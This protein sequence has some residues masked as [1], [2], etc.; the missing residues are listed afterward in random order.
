MS[1][2]GRNQVGLLH[3]ITSNG[4]LTWRGGLLLSSTSRS[5]LQLRTIKGS[6]F[7]KL[8]PGTKFYATS[9]ASPSMDVVLDFDGTITKQD[10]IATLAAYAVSKRDS[11]CS[12]SVGGTAAQAWDRIVRAYSSDYDAYT[13]SRSGGAAALADDRAHERMAAV[14]AELAFLNGLRSVETASIQ[15]IEEARLFQGITPEELYRFGSAVVS[16]GDVQI[17][18][19]FNELVC[20]ARRGRPRHGSGDSRHLAIV[21]VNWSADFIRGCC[22]GCADRRRGSD[23]GDLDLEIISNTI[24]YPTGRIRGFSAGTVAGSD[25]NDND[26]QLLLTARDKLNAVTRLAL[27]W[28]RRVDDL[29]Y[30]GDSATDLEC[31]LACKGIVMVP[32]DYKQDDVGGEQKNRLLATLQRLGYGRLPHVL[33]CDPDFKVAWARDFQEIL[34]SGI[35]GPGWQSDVR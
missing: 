17:R 7:G 29:V 33:K 3:Q 32:D 10:T 20:R 4:P 12:G 8:T 27:S 14:K 11:T 13:A 24:E 22:S 5:L 21:S 1:I 18:R 19:G 6:T 23:L 30:V 15:R 35:L 31:L 16:K 26:T 9:A 2:A 28:G 34:D 25:G